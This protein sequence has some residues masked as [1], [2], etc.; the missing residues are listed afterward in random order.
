VGNFSV[1]KLTAA[2]RPLLRG[3]QSL[4]MAA[5]RV[6][7]PAEKNKTFRPAGRLDCDQE[8]F[9]SLRGLRKKIADAAGV[10]PFVIFSDAA[11]TE[12]AARQPTDEEAFLAV[13]G[14]GVHKLKSYGPQFLDEIRRHAEAQPQEGD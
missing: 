9:A 6:R 10:P 13:H 8:L 7:A 3:E 12:M 5:P 4:T 2:S 11:L 14:V 1:I